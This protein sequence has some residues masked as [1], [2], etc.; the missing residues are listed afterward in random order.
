MGFF[1]KALAAITIADAIDR[2][3]RNRPV[4]YWY[5]NQPGLPATGTSLPY[6]A[7]MYPPPASVGALPA[8][9]GCWDPQHP[10]RPA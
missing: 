5:P 6:V 7:P 3:A 8:A 9:P 4:K 1:F 10:E 2:H